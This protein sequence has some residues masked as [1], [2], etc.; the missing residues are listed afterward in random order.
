MKR[1]ASESIS[2][3]GRELSDATLRLHH[4]VA[5]AA[6]LSGTDHKYLGLLSRHGPMTA[7]QWGKRSGLSSGAV[8]GLVDRLEARALVSRSADPVDRRKILI[9]P[10]AENIQKL[11]GQTS[12]RLERRIVAHAKKLSPRDAQVVEKYLRETIKILNDFS[13][14]L[15][16]N[17]SAEGSC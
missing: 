8:T 3:L 2:D 4:T 7:G 14:S 9:V 13:E 17:E 15:Q 5:A 11:L 16:A 10:N 12:A 6:G 1:D